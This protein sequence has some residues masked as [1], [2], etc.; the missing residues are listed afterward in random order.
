MSTTP[1]PQHT[2]LIAPI[3]SSFG[4]LIGFVETFAQGRADH[5]RVGLATGRPHDLTDEET[6]RGTLAGFVVGDSGRVCGQHRV[7]GRAKRTR[8]RDLAEATRLDYRG[9]GR[10][11][12]VVLALS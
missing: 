4:G 2:R 7:Y 8:I 9:H 12:R 5:R 3:R 10:A 1:R 6:D 11:R